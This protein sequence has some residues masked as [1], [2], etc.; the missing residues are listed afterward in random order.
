MAATSD[1]ALYVT[2]GAIARVTGEAKPVLGAVGA[3]VQQPDGDGWSRLA[4]SFR[5][6]AVHRPPAVGSFEV[7]DHLL[8]KQA[9]RRSHFL[10]RQAAQIHV[11]QEMGHVPGLQVLNGGRDLGWRANGP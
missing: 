8:S 10:V 7:R 6:V 2:L 9:H 11:A 4:A 3:L 5:G 1:K